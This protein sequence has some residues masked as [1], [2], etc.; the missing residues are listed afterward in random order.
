M[1]AGSAYTGSVL[2]GSFPWQ[3]TAG[4]PLPWRPV[5]RVEDT[6]MA[7]VD[8]WERRVAEWPWW[9]TVPMRMRPQAFVGYRI[10]GCHRL[11]PAQ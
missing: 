7:A 11:Y 9:L 6:V 4:K 3:K 5:L 8:F 1:V 2:K 10:D